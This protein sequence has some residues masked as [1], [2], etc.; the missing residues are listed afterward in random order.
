MTPVFRFFFWFMVIFLPV[1]GNIAVVSPIQKNFPFYFSQYIL[2]SLIQSKL[3]FLSISFSF[4]LSLLFGAVA[5]VF[6]CRNSVFCFAFSSKL[7]HSHPSWILIAGISWEIVEQG[8][9]KAKKPH[10]VYTQWR[11]SQSAAGS[12]A[13]SCWAEKVNLVLLKLVKV[14]A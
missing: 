4:I 13:S 9:V 2:N 12:K 6:P 11:G 3:W 14:N 7:I 8:T 5:V 10:A 1:S